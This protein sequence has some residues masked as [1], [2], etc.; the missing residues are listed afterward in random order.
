MPGKVLSA[1]NNGW[2][3]S[4]SRSIDNIIEAFPNRG[5]ELAYGTAVVFDATRSGVKAFDSS[6]AAADFLGFAIRSGS[7]TPN[8]Y[9]A[10]RGSYLPG[11]TAEILTR[12]TIV[13]DLAEGTP[14]AGGTVY[15]VKATGAVSAAADGENTVELTS[16]RFRGPVDAS[17]RVEVVLTARNLI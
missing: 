15:L 13:V 11:E 10:S 4:V 14:E 7:K 5:A 2:S 16:A 3:G 1:F 6:S 8:T 9:G 12:G 17:G